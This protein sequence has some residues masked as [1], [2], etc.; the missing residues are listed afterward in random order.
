MAKPSEAIN[1]AAQF[2]QLVLIRPWRLFRIQFNF[3]K[4]KFIEQENLSYTLQ[5]KKI[6]ALLFI[7]EIISRDRTI[8]LSKFIKVL[9][10]MKSIFGLW[11]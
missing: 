7:R 11:S 4:S 5:S 10:R 6:I 1:S 3:V 2:Q 9:K 8:T